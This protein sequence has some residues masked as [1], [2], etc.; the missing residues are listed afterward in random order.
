MDLHGMHFSAKPA[1]I[2]T[3]TIWVCREINSTCIDWS[4]EWDEWPREH[5]MEFFHKHCESWV[6][7]NNNHNRKQ[8]NKK[9]MSTTKWVV[10]HYYTCIF[11]QNYGLDPTIE[12]WDNKKC[13]FC[14]S[15]GMNKTVKWSP[16]EAIW[17]G[18]QA[19]ECSNINVDQTS[20]NPACHSH[21]ISF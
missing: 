17:R 21:I 1:E 16:M 8:T 18:K 13:Q 10:S 15:P 11:F 12:A 9:Q 4:T 3:L 6:L 20:I 14:R 5:F 7:R 2:P 19:L